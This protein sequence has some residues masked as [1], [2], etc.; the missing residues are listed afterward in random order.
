M[1]FEWDEEKNER[2]IREHGFGF[3]DAAPILDTPMSRWLDDRRH[4]GEER[5][6]GLG[7][8]N[9][10]VVAFTYTMRGDDIWRWISLRK[11]NARETK[12][13]IQA[14]PG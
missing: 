10:R 7:V 9:G 1:R 11:A 12:R 13:Y 3:A 4:Y 2:N 6:C 14:L 5:W 8:L